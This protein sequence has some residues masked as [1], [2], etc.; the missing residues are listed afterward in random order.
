MRKRFTLLTLFS[1][2]CSLISLPAT[3]DVKISNL[4]DF[5][6]GLYSG[7]GNLRNDD[8]ICINAVPISRYQLTV[9][10]TGSGG[11]FEVSN[12]VDTIPFVVRFRANNRRGNTV[13]TPGVALTRLRRATDEIDCPSGLNANFDVQFRRANLQA[14]NPGRYTGQLIVT[15]A[16]E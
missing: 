13:V 4:D 2:G 8:N 11:V 7:F 12:G 9:W 3:S 16:P 6:F 15:I 1:F 10:G 14:A 5:N